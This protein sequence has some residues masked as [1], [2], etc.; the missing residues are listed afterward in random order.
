[1]ASDVIQ[2]L[3]ACSKL[4]A[5]RCSTFAVLVAA[6]VDGANSSE[7]AKMLN[8]PVRFANLALKRAVKEGLMTKTNWLRNGFAVYRLTGLGGSIVK[9]LK[10]D[11]AP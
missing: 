5:T 1:M 10:K 8:V 4:G 11:F 2:F 6:E 9:Q 7:T 3:L